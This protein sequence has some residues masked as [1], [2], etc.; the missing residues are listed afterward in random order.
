M[1][2]RYTAEDIVT[3]VLYLGAIYLLLAF[4]GILTPNAMWQ[5]FMGVVAGSYVLRVFREQK[6]TNAKANDPTNEP[7]P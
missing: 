5:A 7:K 2:P 1:H 3:D 4:L 6:E